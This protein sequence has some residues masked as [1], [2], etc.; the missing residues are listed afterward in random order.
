RRQLLLYLL[1]AL[2]SVRVRLCARAEFCFSRLPSMLSTPEK[3]EGGPRTR[4][5]TTPTTS[6]RAL[7]SD[8]CAPRPR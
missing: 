8:R 6:D 2:P 7:E 4:S 5:H 1:Y 3:D